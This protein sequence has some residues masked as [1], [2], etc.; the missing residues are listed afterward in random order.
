MEY[1]LGDILQ[2]VQAHY[3]MEEKNGLIKGGAQEYD[4]DAVLLKLL[5]TFGLG[6]FRDFNQ[7]REG[8]KFCLKTFRFGSEWRHVSKGGF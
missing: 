5:E 6:R 8:S 1:F 3:K 4:G 2:K 7:T